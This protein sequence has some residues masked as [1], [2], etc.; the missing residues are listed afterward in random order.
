MTSHDELD[1]AARACSPDYEKAAL[2][3]ELGYRRAIILEARPR[4]LRRAESARI[5]VSWRDG[6]HGRRDDRHVNHDGVDLDRQQQRNEEGT[7]PIANYAEVEQLI[8]ASIAATPGTN[9]SIYDR[10]L[11]DPQ[12]PAFQAEPH[13]IYFFYIR[14]NEN[15]A[16]KV[17]HYLYFEGPENDPSQWAKIPYDQVDAK[18]E[19]LARNARPLGAGN[20]APLPDHNFENVVFNRKCYV[21]YFLDEANWSYHSRAV[22]ENRY[23]VVYNQAKAGGAPNTSFFDAK[24]V[25]FAMTSTSGIETIR[26]GV[27]L[28]NHMK[29]DRGQ[30]LGAAAQQKFAFD[31]YFDVQFVDPSDSRLVVV[32]DPDGTNLGPPLP[33]P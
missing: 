22:A 25:S 32:F 33:P 29:D 23:G 28:I 16:L 3:H 18:V 13:C 27:V 7:M 4:A 9:P 11:G 15:G 26:T 10:R 8:A 1:A 20:P 31:M 2:V 21:A 24:D 19:Y 14:F 30:D 17:D 6:D 12:F 5:R